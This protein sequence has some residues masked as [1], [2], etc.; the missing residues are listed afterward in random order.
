M[1]YSSGP[2]IWSWLMPEALA[3]KGFRLVPLELYPAFW[4]SF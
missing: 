4:D 1:F 2:R 3:F